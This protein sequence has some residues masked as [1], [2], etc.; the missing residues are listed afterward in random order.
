MKISE[1][2]YPKENIPNEIFKLGR[3]LL[4]GNISGISSEI[5]TYEQKLADFFKSRNAVAVSSGSAAIITALSILGIGEGDEVLIPATSVLPSA[6]PLL[7]AKIKPIIVDTLVDGFAFDP[8][9]LKRKI[10]SKTKAAILVYMWGYPINYIETKK[11]LDSFNIPLIEDASQAHGSMYDNNYLGTLGKIGCFSTNDRKILSTGE[12]GFI[13]TNEDDIAI[14][15]KDYSTF[16]VM[17]GQGP[18]SNFR[19]SSLQAVL[20]ISRIKLIKKQI[21]KRKQK[22]HHILERLKPLGILPISLD[23]KA[24][25]NYYS[26]LVL[27]PWDK[28]ENLEFIQ[29]TH[30]KG[31]PSD[32]IRYGYC[33]I[34]KKDVFKEYDTFCPNAELFISKLANIPIRP[35]MKVKEIDYIVDTYYS[36]AKKLFKV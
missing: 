3:K 29:R 6:L 25:P 10:T 36:E 14:K 17:K 31:I 34:G 27:L 19:I 24:F 13:L 4:N 35:D 20:G 28:E 32:I 7:S 2:Y 1:I 21:L 5:S 33:T 23:E 9:D 30:I 12:G 11:I 26:L 8:T 16:G 18:S 15:A 22:V